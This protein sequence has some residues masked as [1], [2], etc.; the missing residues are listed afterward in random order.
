[1]P[2][3]DIAKDLVDGVQCARDGY[4]KYKRCDQRCDSKDESCKK[5]C[6]CKAGA[7]GLSCLV[8]DLT[9]K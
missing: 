3:T 6:L 4:E 2:Y 1:M 5:D 7:D 8:H 9:K